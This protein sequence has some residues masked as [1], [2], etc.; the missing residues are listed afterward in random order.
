[1]DPAN[2]VVLT[3]TDG[4]A[5]WVVHDHHDELAPWLVT[6]Q[7]TR[8]D[9]E[10]GA[11]GDVPVQ[12]PG[13]VR[14]IPGQVSSEPDIGRFGQ[15]GITLDSQSC[16]IQHPTAASVSADEVLAAHRQVLARRAVPDSSSHSAVILTQ[17]EEFMIEPQ[18]ADICFDDRR[19]Q[20]GFQHRLRTVGH[21][22]RAGLAVIGCA[23]G[24]G[25]PCLQPGH[26]KA[27]KAG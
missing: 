6:D 23:V 21:R 26:F 15:P 5:V 18:I 16:L 14:E 27:S 1:M 22:A 24:T 11:R 20:Q 13:S 17:F 2:E 7:R 19:H 3:V 10:V 8:A 25:T 4:F 12:D 9:H